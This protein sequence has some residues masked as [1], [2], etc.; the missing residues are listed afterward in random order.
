MKTYA[1]RLRPGHDLREELDRFS[2]DRDIKAGSIITCVGS[3][4]RAVLRMADEN[5]TKSFDERFEI[6]SLVG[7]L[8]Q[9]GNHIHISLSDKDGKTIGGHLKKGCLIYSTA[10]IVIGESDE[11]SFSREFDEQTG[12][13]ELI[14]ENKISKPWSS[15]IPTNSR[16]G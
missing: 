11:F 10:E 14:I 3:L 12:F 9:D 1:I 5:I 13:K 4:K 8:S 16:S 2:K 7:T 6:V 15:V